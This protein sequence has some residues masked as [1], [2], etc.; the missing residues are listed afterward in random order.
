M[1][2]YHSK[3][4][5]IDGIE[6]DSKK[7]ANRYCELKL[8]QRSGKISELQIQVP[9]I[10][11]PA[12]YEEVTVYTEKTKKKKQEKK[13]VERKLKYI[14]D[15]V[16]KK[17]GKIVVEDAK[18]YRDGGAYALFVVKRKLMLFIHGIK[19]IEV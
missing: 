6:F 17:D 14:A 7:E 8:L 16:Y 13:L 12:Q 19:V 1:S 15:F 9:F 11:I 5:I 10:L 18:G 2:K 3:K 4:Q